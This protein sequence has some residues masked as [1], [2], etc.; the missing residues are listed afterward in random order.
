MKEEVAHSISKVI[1]EDLFLLC[2]TFNFSFH[3]TG[4]KRACRRQ[5]DEILLIAMATNEKIEEVD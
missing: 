1:C 2:K 5:V 4:S 3:F